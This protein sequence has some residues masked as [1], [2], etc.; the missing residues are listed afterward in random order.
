[1]KFSG[2][3]LVGTAGENVGDLIMGGKKALNLGLPQNWGSG[4][5]R[6]WWG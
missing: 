5:Y 3:V 6:H 2:G 4:S 1:M